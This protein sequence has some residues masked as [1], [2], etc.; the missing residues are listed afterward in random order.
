MND[1]SFT[2]SDLISGYVKSYKAN[3]RTIDL[4]TSDGRSYR[5]TLTGNTYAKQTQNLNE[6]WLD[7]GGQLDELL[8]PGKMVFL[9]GTFFPEEQTSFEVNFI[10]FASD[11]NNLYRYSEQGWWINQI[12]CIATSY[13]KWQFNVP[14][15]PIDYKNYRTPLVLREGSKRKT[16]C[17]KRTPFPEWF[18]AWHQLIC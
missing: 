14:T 10:V 2:F 5:A 11:T 6:G 4:I 12:D 7:R 8:K 1:I 17:K 18:M 15:E 13:L 3:E 16:T 9:Y